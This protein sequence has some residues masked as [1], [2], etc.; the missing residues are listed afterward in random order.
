MQS[1][2]N[3]IKY[4]KALGHVQRAERLKEILREYKEIRDENRR[5]VNKYREVSRRY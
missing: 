2:I 5:S 1:L 4:L 3:K